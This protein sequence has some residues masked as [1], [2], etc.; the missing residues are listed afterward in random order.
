MRTPDERRRSMTWAQRFKRVFGID[1]STSVHCGG[2][3]C[4]VAS[5]EEAHAIPA[6]LDHFEKHGAMEE[7]HYRP[8]ARTA[9]EA[10]P[11]RD[12]TVEDETR[13]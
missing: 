7:V 1:V 6:I 12:R 9:H 11:E 13:T 3:V 4:I 8:A 5:V 10:C 2:A